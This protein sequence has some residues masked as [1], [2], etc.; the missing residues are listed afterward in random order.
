M[1]ETRMAVLLHN[2]RIS[3]REAG[4]MLHNSNGDPDFLLLTYR[5]ARDV[6]TA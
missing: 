4:V 6:E 2:T 1:G 3:A 5:Y